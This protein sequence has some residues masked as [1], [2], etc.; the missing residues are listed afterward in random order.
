M[1]AAQAPAGAM[2]NFLSTAGE[3]QLLLLYVDHVCVNNGI[4]IPWDDVAVAMEPRN[5]A[6]G[7]IPMTGEAIKQH[8]AKVRAA[9]ES[10]DMTVP[11]KLDRAARR[12]AA[13]CMKNGVPMTPASVKGKAAGV[14]YETPKVSQRSSLLA[15]LTKKDEA[16]LKRTAK[17]DSAA[18]T[19]AA[20]K[21]LSKRAHGRVTKK[22][23]EDDDDDDDDD[24]DEDDYLGTPVAATG[25]K[26][27]RTLETKDYALLGADDDDDVEE[28][29][30]LLASGDGI[31]DGPGESDHEEPA[32]K[33]AKTEKKAVRSKGSRKCSRN[34]C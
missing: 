7:G 32:T 9:R 26:K 21:M 27:L 25:T 16:K 31:Y 10:A 34:A 29:K 5:S 12:R 20:P 30:A 17:T 2:T 18:K 11:P 19:R 24:D 13:N 3:D 4:A 15:P 28:D 22:K 33:K 6:K 8:L 23:V 14:V 1:L